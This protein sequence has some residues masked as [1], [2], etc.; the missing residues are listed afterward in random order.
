[1]KK[2]LFPLLTVA[3]L[4]A[5]GLYWLTDNLDEI[6]A[7]AITQHGSAMSQARVGVEKV[8][9]APSSG[10]GVVTDLQVGNPKGFKTPFALRASSIAVDIDL[11]T[12]TRDVTVIRSLVIDRPDVIYEKSN[13][14]TN[15]DEIQKN[16]AVYLGPKGKPRQQGNIRLIVEELTLC[17]AN[18][19]ASG[20]FLS[21]KSI[22][23]P[24]PD[25]TL[26]NVGLARG[27]VTPGE[28]GQEIANA[29]NSKLRIV[30]NFE[31]LKKSTGESPDK[32]AAA[33]KG[34]QK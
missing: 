34:P 22:S 23:I 5:G 30:G 8:E 12:L 17:N 14:T 16:I 6:V 28:L 2:L 26:K 3:L 33:I 10:K 32:G 11:A 27:G 15:F 29:L 25:I 24:L 4:V 21:N 31:R 18:A 9:I 1:V 19:Q 13:G 20:G 7:E